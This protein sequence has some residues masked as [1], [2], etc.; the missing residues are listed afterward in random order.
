MPPHPTAWSNS[1]QLIRTSPSQSVVRCACAG[2]ENEN[3]SAA[4]LEKVLAR[5]YANTELWYLLG[6]VSFLSG[7][8]KRASEAFIEMIHLN[9]SNASVWYMKGCAEYL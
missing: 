9:Q 7:S 4:Q 1:T 8:M 6:V 5:G 3:E 2:T